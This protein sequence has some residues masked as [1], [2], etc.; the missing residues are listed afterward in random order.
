VRILFLGDIMGRTGRT[1]V[2]RHLAQVREEENIDLVLANGENASGGLGLSAKSSRELFGAGV[3]AMT[4]GN[5]IWKFRDIIP[6]LEG[7]NLLRP[8]NYPHGSPGRGWAVFEFQGLAPLAVINLQGRTFM[9]PIDCP[10][11]A[12]ERILEEIPDHVRL[13]VVDFHAE[14]TS[15]KLA[16]AWM[17]DGRVSAMLGTHT[18]VPTGDARIFPQGMA[19]MT[20]LGM[21]G[22]RDSCLGMAPG[23]IIRRFV[24][25]LPQKYRIAS[26]PGVLQGAIFD[27]DES[28]GTAS[29]ITAWSMHTG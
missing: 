8:A 28:S 1:A 7:G 19:Y 27:L 12:L 16:L 22:P 11:A 23:P 26:G 6:V 18:H 5:H 4:S 3:N 17:A 10:F 15:E 13:R 29:S 25:G 20:D 21:C 9:E 24:T 14:A 2:K